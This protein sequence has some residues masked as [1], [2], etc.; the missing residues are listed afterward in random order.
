MHQSEYSLLY[1]GR[2]VNEEEITLVIQV[3]FAAFVNDPHKIIFRGFRIRD[4]LVDLAWNE[5]GLVI[6]VVYA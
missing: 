2:E 3:I 1:Y 6:G 4:D 5:R